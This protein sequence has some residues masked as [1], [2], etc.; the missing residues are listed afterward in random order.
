MANPG[1]SIT[2]AAG[3]INAGAGTTADPTLTE[4]VSYTAGAGDINITTGTG[5]DSFNKLVSLIII[6][7]FSQSSISFINIQISHFVISI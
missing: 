4:A 1:V 5:D 7:F 3:I 2:L 6:L